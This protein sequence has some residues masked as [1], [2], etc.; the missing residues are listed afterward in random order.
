M[1][2]TVKVPLKL[3]T[4]NSVKKFNDLVQ[5]VSDEVYLTQGRYVVDAKSIMGIFSLSLMDEV[6]MITENPSD[7]FIEF[8]RNVEKYIE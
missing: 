1:S 4:I 2:L 8:L 3:N 5:D 7:S 6:E